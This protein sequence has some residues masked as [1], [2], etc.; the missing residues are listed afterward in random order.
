MARKPFSAGCFALLWLVI[1][2]VSA[3]D[4]FRCVQDAHFL[5]DVE[6]NPIARWILRR[7]GVSLLV[8]CKFLGNSLVLG[9]LCWT[10]ACK[11]R[12]SIPIICAVALAQLFVLFT[13][14]PNVPWG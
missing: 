8:G 3:Y 6:L 11:R 2:A 13:Y 4:T 5:I 9:V 10:W 7:G 14:C 1:A 12:F